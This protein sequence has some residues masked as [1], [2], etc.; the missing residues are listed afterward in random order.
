MKIILPSMILLTAGLL[1][2]A[3]LLAVSCALLE[4]RPRTEELRPETEDR[5]PQ[6]AGWELISGERTKYTTEDGHIYTAR[7][8][9][10]HAADECAL[11]V[12]DAMYLVKRFYVDEVSYE[13]MM[14]AAEGGIRERQIVA[15]MERRIRVTTKHTKDTK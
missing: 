11:M 2:I 5:R 9:D 6:N 13:T 7:N 4:P 14:A 3:G 10:L 15:A 12:L 1:A 8:Y